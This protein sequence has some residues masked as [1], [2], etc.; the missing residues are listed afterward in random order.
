MNEFLSYGGD[1]FL[2]HV[3]PD[4]YRFNQVIDNPYRTNCVNCAIATDLSL[5]YI[6]GVEVVL[7]PLSSYLSS[8]TTDREIKYSALPSTFKPV[9]E[10]EDLYSMEFQDILTTEDIEE[11]AINGNTAEILL[12]G[13]KMIR[14]TIQDAGE[15]S[16]GI[17]Y[18][19]TE[20]GNSGHV[21]NVWNKGGSTVEFLDGQRNRIV[22]GFLSKT[23]LVVLLLT[24]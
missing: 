11:G 18:V 21:F 6:Q 17:I 10:I 1:A 15:K 9:N 16:R 5:Q 22:T 8:T 4:F 19:Q 13:M 23:S 2:S 3:N 20:D 14:S 7:P 24:S 12:M